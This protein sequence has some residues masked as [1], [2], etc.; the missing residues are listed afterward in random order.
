MYDVMFKSYGEFSGWEFPYK[1]YCRDGVM[2]NG[3]YLPIAIGIKIDMDKVKVSKRHVDDARWDYLTGYEE[4][5]RRSA[6][7]VNESV[8]RGDWMDENLFDLISKLYDVAGKARTELKDK[9]LSIK[10]REI[11]DELTDLR[12]EGITGRLSHD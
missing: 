2:E 4:S 10:L 11:A 12:W 5:T 8:D 6:R 3:N 7:R 9:N 1:Q